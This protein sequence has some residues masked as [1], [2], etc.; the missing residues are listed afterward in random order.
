MGQV[1]PCSTQHRATDPGSRDKFK[2]WPA[3]VLLDN[4][5]AMLVRSSKQS[6]EWPTGKLKARTSSRRTYS[7]L[8]FEGDQVLLVRF[9]AII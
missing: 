6:A 9:Y 4:A 2:L 1:I 8:F 3:C 7:K 5:P